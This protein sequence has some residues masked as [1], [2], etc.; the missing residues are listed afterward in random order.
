[1]FAQTNLLFCVAFSKATARAALAQKTA[2]FLFAKLFLFGA[3]LS[4]RKSV[5]GI[6]ISIVSGTILKHQTSLAAFLWQ[7]RRK[8]K[9]TKETLSTGLRAPYPRHCA[10]GTTFEKVDETTGGCGDIFI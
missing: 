6:L 8:E 5:N 10:W 2:L 9:L 7:N 3:I 1:M 4:K